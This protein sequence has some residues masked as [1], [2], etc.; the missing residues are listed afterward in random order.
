MD[1]MLNSG[2]CRIGQ[3]DLV[4]FKRVQKG[5]LANRVKEEF[6]GRV[7]RNADDLL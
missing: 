2:W 4:A 1:V 3:D 6:A 5:N 7:K